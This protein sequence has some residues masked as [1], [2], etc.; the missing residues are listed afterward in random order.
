MK[1][2]VFMSKKL[3]MSFATSLGGQSSLTVD[4]PKE[5]LTEADVRTV[6]DSI[7]TNNI[8]N[9]TK[10]NLAGVKAAEIVTTTTETLI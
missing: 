4:E 8:F 2:G 3:S 6:M 5:G 7:I 1:E 9:T 10:G